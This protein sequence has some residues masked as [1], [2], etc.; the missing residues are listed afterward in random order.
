M[1][2]EFIFLTL[3]MVYTTVVQKLIYQTGPCYD[4]PL[5][6][7]AANDR[8]IPNQIS[9]FRQVPTYFGGALA[10]VFC[11]TTRSEYAYNQSPKRMKT[12]VQAIWFAMAGMGTCLALV[13]SPLTKDPHL[14]TMYAILT[15]LLG[16]ATILL[17]VLFWR[18]D[19][20]KFKEGVE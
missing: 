5:A 11:L 13:F 7:A 18:L 14:V 4:T 2:V 19:M 9:V 1:L 10:E 16:G 3:F 6:C 12:L 15:G 8:N 20:V 17:W